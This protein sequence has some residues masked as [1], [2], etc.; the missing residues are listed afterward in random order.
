MATTPRKRTTTNETTRTKSPT[1]TRTRTKDPTSR[2]RRRTHE[3]AT[4]HRQA[5]IPRLLRLAA[6]LRRH[7]LELFRLGPDVLHVSRR[8]LADRPRHLAAAVRV[9]SGGLGRAGRAGGDH[10]SHGR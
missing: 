6:R 2:R 8:L 10:A 4:D 9:R 5:R 3:H 7:L 1:R